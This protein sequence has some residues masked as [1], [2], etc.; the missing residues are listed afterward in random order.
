[1]LRICTHGLES[2]AGEEAPQQAKMIVSAV[3]GVEPAALAIH[4][5]VQ[6]TEE[7]IRQIGELMEERL[8]GKPLQYILGEWSFM[9]L[10][11]YTDERAL[12]PR[13]DT[14]LL[15][16]TAIQY[17]REREYKTCLDLC[18]GG[19]CVAISVAKS[20][21]VEMT[22]SDISEDALS[23]A[24]ENASLN[25]TK[26][27]F[28]KSDL[29]G[30]IDGKYDLISCNPPYLT[31]EDMQHL[32]KEFT[33]EPAMALYGGG[34]GL[35]FYRKIAWEY[36]ARLNKGGTLLLEIGSTQA[37]AAAALFDAKTSVL[38]EL[39]GNPRVLVVE[40]Q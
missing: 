40:P 19:G 9:G 13:Q 27:R 34:D 37:Q 31:L 5:W 18:T 7:Q 1:M 3:L 21:G 36:K 35:D 2:L 24:R 8:T 14:E 4:L 33:F 22:A 29:F 15:A 30:Q 11:F 28:I 17:C 39:G 32:Q 12:I 10:P 6:L 20:S 26:I 23:L 38:N 25:E 16:Q